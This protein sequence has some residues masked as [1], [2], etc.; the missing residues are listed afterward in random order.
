MWQHLCLTILQ[1]EYRTERACQLPE[2]LGSALRGVLGQELLAVSCEQPGSPCEWCRRPDRC[3]SGALFDSNGVGQS[4]F[5]GAAPTTGEPGM[6]VARSGGSAG[7][8]RPRPYVLVTPSRNRGVYAAGDSIRLG[9]TLVGH[10]RVWYPWVVAALAQ[11]GRRGLGVERVQ[12]SLSRIVAIEPSGKPVE[13]NPESRG[14]GGHVP[15]LDAR[16]ILAEAP[17]PAREAVVAFLTPADLQRKGDRIERLDGPTLFRRLIRRIGTLVETYCL[18]PADAGPCDFHALGMMADQVTV[19][20]Q[21]VSMQT[22]DR[23][24]NRIDRKHPLS[25]LVG[26]ALLGD[27]PEPLWPYLILGQWVHV[28]KAASF[29]QGRYKVVLQAE[30]ASQPAS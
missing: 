17:G 10:A 6:G 15:E 3:A 27:I 9:F 18:I 13:I 16:Q 11:L 20:E 7:F 2:Y 14:I 23:Y 5:T 1:A 26:H 19:K 22:W 24:S 30:P 4:A 28:G 29:G 25:G 12:L 21:H 8:D